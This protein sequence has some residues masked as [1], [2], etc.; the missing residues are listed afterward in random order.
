MRTALLTSAA[1]LLFAGAASAEPFTSTSKSEQGVAVAAPAVG[2][3][4]ALRAGASKGSL[5]ATFQS[6]RI[7]KADFS[8]IGWFTVGSPQTAVCQAVSGADAYS[9]RVTCL[10]PDEKTRTGFCQGVLIGTGGRYAGKT[11]LFSQM[12]R[13]DGTAT[14]QGAWND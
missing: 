8:C 10:Q 13:P 6:G 5:T 14:A 7:E 9:M 11:G 2:G 12:N 1:T 3:F 4:L